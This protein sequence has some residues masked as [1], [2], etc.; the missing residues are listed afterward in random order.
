MDEM[1]KTETEPQEEAPAGLEALARLEERILETV[2]ELRAARQEKTEA[3]HE[4]ISLRDQIGRLEQE[5][6]KLRGEAEAFRKE[7]RQILE[8]V[9]KL[10]SQIDS[11]SR[12]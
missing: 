6:R 5:N 2:E 10:V 11:L 4:R 3:E 1:T 12:K 9:E 7:R 8:R